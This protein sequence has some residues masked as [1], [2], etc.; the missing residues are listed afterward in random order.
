MTKCDL[1]S[2]DKKL[3]EISAA[4][5]WTSR[6]HQ[7]RKS[8]RRRSALLH[9][10][11]VRPEHALFVPPFSGASSQISNARRCDRERYIVYSCS[12]LIQKQLLFGDAHVIVEC[13]SDTLISKFVCVTWDIFW[14]A[15]IDMCMHRLVQPQAIMPI[16]RSI[17]VHMSSRSVSEALDQRCNGHRR[18]PHAVL[19]TES[20]RHVSFLPKQLVHLVVKILVKYRIP[21]CAREIRG[22]LT[23]LQGEKFACPAEDDDN[24][25]QVIEDELVDQPVE[26]Q[27]EKQPEQDP[28][29]AEV[30]LRP[31]HAN[32]GH[33]S[34]G[35]DA[36][37]L[38]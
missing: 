27:E 5:R 9:I 32:L 29:A 28:H 16:H 34:K 6:D 22:Q 10:N 7:L 2:S 8:D 17:F 13:V 1:W 38:S 15:R 24:P 23:C 11:A 35:A 31:V 12:F 4:E 3:H 26:L 18:L 19:T 21:S 20:V 25:D 33:P 14:R 37:S 30:M 36:T